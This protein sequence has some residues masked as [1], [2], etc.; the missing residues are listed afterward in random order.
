MELVSLFGE[1]TSDELIGS[2]LLLAHSPSAEMRTGAAVA[3]R[4]VAMKADVR[5]VGLILLG[6]TW[7]ASPFV[8]ATAG[9]VL[10]SLPD[11]SPDVGQSGLLMQRLDDLLDED[12]EV[13]PSAL[14]RGLRDRI[15]IG[16]PIP[17]RLRGRAR[18]S[19]ERHLSWHVRAA[20]THFLERL[21]K[22]D[23]C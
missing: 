7:D 8:R 6:L 23:E 2:L 20:A 19:A 22:A 21:E 9:R 15:E 17:E 5:E 16:L 18:L 10:C 13:V 3:C 4:S 14:W 12:G 1:Q 11:P